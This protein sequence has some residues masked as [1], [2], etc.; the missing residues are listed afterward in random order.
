MVVSGNYTLTNRGTTTYNLGTLTIG[1]GGTIR[2]EATG[3]LTLAG[4]MVGGGPNS[5]GILNLGLL[6]RVIAPNN[7]LTTTITGPLDNRSMVDVEGVLIVSGAVAQLSQPGAGQVAVLSAGHWK[8]RTM[9]TLDLPGP[10]ERIGPNAVVDLIGLSNV[11]DLVGFLRENRG[12]M[13]FSGSRPG[14]SGP[15]PT[16]VNRGLMQMDG[17]QF[18]LQASPTPVEQM[19]AGRT[20]VKNGTLQMHGVS[21]QTRDF[22]NPGTIIIERGKLTLDLDEGD[23]QG[24]FRNTGTLDIRSNGQLLIDG[25]MQTTGAVITEI[26]PLFRGHVF[27][28]RAL[29]IGG[30]LQANYVGAGFTTPHTAVIFVV[31]AMSVTGSFANFSAAGVPQGMSVSLNTMFGVQVLMQS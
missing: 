30:T 9:S 6:R 27:M 19:P 2:N 12:T 1:P 18:S 13:L 4:P 21:G 20:V 16:I 14:I 31:S 10:I 17:D 8:V 22:A 25:A 29:T 5:G 11:P 24:T 15:G 28:N 7:N 23:Q 3:T 26:G